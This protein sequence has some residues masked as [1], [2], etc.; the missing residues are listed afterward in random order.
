M[1]VKAPHGCGAFTKKPK[2]QVQLRC[3]GYPNGPAPA[4]ELSLYGCVYRCNAAAIAAAAS[5]RVTCVC[6][7]LSTSLFDMAILLGVA[8]CAGNAL[9]SA[10]FKS[11]E[12]IVADG[13]NVVG[14]CGCM[15]PD[16]TTAEMDTAS[17]LAGETSVK[18]VA[19]GPG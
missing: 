12:V 6:A 7:P 16:L 14:D 3:I 13:A 15:K 2:S 17:I 9:A 8:I 18:P 1:D 10:A 11:W 19:R 4:Q 5:A